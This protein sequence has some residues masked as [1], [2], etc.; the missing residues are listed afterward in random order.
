[1]IEIN[2]LKQGMNREDGK[3]KN[4]STTNNNNKNKEHA[5]S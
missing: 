4:L 5:C 1:M 2:K 3:K